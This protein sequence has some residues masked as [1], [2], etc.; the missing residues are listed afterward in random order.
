MQCPMQVM[1]HGSVVARYVL[2]DVRVNDQVVSICGQRGAIST[3]VEMF[4]IEVGIPL[5]LEIARSIVLYAD[6]IDEVASKSLLGS[7]VKDAIAGSREAGR[8]EF[9][10]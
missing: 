1:Q 8:F 3:Q 7:E 2:H 5:G 10:R 4:D 6:S 9:Q